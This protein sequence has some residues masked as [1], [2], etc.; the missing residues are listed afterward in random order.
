MNELN[1]Q[2][3][4]SGAMVRPIGK[5]FSARIIDNAC[6]MCGNDHIDRGRILHGHCVCEECV[7]IIIS[8]DG[9]AGDDLP[10]RPRL[11]E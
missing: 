4:R 5:H 7:R 11:A 2:N 3:G 6:V 10:V 1:F 9:C 8:A